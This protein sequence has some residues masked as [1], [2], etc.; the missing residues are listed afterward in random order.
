M[1]TEEMISRAIEKVKGDTI[2]DKHIKT[3]K[4]VYL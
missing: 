4:I 1:V 3:K 2:T